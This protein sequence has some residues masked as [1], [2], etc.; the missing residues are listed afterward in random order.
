MIIDSQVHVWNVE[1]DGVP[2]PHKYPGIYES[3]DPS[4]LLEEMDRSGVSGAVL[5][6]KT[7]A[8]LESVLEDAR[9]CRDR[10]CAFAL[11][12]TQA[13]HVPPP[14]RRA[15]RYG[16]IVGVRVLA[17]NAHSLTSVMSEPIWDWIEAHDVPVM[18]SAPHAFDELAQLA[19]RR[20]RIRFAL[21]HLGL[22]VDDRAAD[23]L[24][25]L[26]PD[27][28]ALANLPNVS[29]KASGLPAHTSEPYPFPALHGP[30]RA[31]VQAFE[32]QR[33]FWGSDL[34]RSPCRY[35]QALGFLQLPNFLEPDEWDLVLGGA[36]AAWS[37]WS[38]SMQPTSSV[39]EP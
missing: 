39:V 6:P 10:F 28:L 7:V 16:E 4:M 2:I 8:A 23:S 19:T 37:G 12:E 33:V 30:L 36:F 25:R 35:D 14:V 21:D 38:P 27:L 5:I 26:L 29:V 32:P 13:A 17:R 24:A 15:H 20:P 22:D 18:V 9:R 34:S 1:K 3:L 31:V 11:I